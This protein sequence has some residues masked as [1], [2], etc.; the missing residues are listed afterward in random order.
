M[1]K[2][3]KSIRKELRNLAGMAY[4]RELNSFLEEIYNDFKRWKEGEI[5]PFELSKLIHEFHDGVSRQLYNINVNL[6][7]D[8]LTARAVAFGFI[9]EAELPSAIKKDIFKKA[10]YYKDD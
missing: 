2:Y 7:P 1:E 9:E 8:Q 4:E 10:E 6:K 5:D 3:P